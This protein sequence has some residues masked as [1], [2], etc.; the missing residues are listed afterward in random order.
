MFT[1]I[2]IFDVAQVQLYIYFSFTFFF[3]HCVAQSTTESIRNLDIFQHIL[4][5]YIIDPSFSFL[6]VHDL[7]VVFSKLCP[8]RYSDLVRWMLFIFQPRLSSWLI[9]KTNCSKLKNRLKIPTGV[10]R[11]RKSMN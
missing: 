1:N 4:L 3:S 2:C 7:D 11:S 5:K 8:C 6:S 9:I 10:I